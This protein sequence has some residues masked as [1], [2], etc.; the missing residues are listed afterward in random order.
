M[1]REISEVGLALRSG[2]YHW[3][4]RNEIVYLVMDNAGGHGM[5]DATTCYTQLL[6]DEFRVKLI[7]QVPRS[8]E[9][10]MLDLSIWMSIQLLAAVTASSEF[11]TSEDAIRMLWQQGYKMHGTTICHQMHLK[12]FV[13]D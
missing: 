2:V 11:T 4:P 6:W 9:T 13:E 7:W 10:N 8:P 12:M 1:L 5:N 3:I